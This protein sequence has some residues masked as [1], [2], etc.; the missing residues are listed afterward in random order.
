MV[1]SGNLFLPLKMTTITDDKIQVKAALI[2]LEI[3]KCRCL[4]SSVFMS[5]TASNIA[6]VSTHVALSL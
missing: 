1:S 5:D 6:T 4:N 3:Q 2:S